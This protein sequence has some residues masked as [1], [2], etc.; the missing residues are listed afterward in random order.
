MI[1]NYK[2]PV[3]ALTV[4]GMESESFYC[5][6]D[7]FFGVI[8]PYAPI[9][10]LLFQRNCVYMITYCLIIFTSGNRKCG[11]LAAGWEVGTI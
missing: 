9:P 4:V 1:S 5:R 8:P 7:C 6:F 2:L 10:C 3:V 11:M